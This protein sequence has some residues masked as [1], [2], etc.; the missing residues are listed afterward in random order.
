[1]PQPTLKGPHQHLVLFSTFSGASIF[2]KRGN[3]PKT[4]PTECSNASNVHRQATAF[5][6]N[7]FQKGLFFWARDLAFKHFPF[8]RQLSGSSREN[9]VLTC[10]EQLTHAPKMRLSA[11]LKI[12]SGS[13]QN[14]P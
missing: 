1:M 7:S 9:S 3:V 14:C 2:Q 12:S 4:S 5:L 11:F 6:Q 8:L 13:V 10:S